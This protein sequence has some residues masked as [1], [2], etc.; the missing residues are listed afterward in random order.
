MY[1]IRT[2]RSGRLLDNTLIHNRGQICGDKFVNAYQ[3]EVMVLKGCAIFL[4]LPP[5]IAN[6]IDR[7]LENRD[8][9][10]E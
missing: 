5:N 7:G 9:V 10:F 4:V 8:L 6:I 1:R 3:F 2:K